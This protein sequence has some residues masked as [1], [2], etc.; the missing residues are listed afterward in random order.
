M[1][2]FNW[3]FL[4]LIYA[5][6]IFIYGPCILQLCAEFGSVIICAIA[7][8]AKQWKETIKMLLERD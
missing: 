7:D 8:K 2:V 4:T 6:F 3:V 1:N 5:L